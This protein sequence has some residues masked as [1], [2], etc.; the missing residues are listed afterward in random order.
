MSHL[1]PAASP[2]E[3][4]PE[5]IVEDDRGRKGFELSKKPYEISSFECKGCPNVCEIN[6][7]KISGEKGYLF[8]GGRCEKYDVRKKKMTS[9]PDLFA[10]RD[11]MLWKEHLQ[12]RE[13]HEK[14]TILSLYQIFILQKN[15]IKSWIK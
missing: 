9:I 8:Y 14:T 12:R 5:V 1:E 15:S 10:F 13:L 6:R 4:R 11:E 3:E 7:V 2:P